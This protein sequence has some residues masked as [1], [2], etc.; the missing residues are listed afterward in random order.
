MASGRTPLNYPVTAI[1]RNTPQGSRPADILA[2]K[3]SA[4][5][6]L[7]AKAPPFPPAAGYYQADLRCRIEALMMPIDLLPV[8][9]APPIL[10][11][12]ANPTGSTD[13][14]VYHLQVRAEP[15]G[16][17]VHETCTCEW[18]AEGVSTL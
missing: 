8:T 1:T 4:R 16:A 18:A 7:S 14:L 5:D 10:R 15:T 2:R 17:W 6:K 3:R 12:S 13:L 11:C 9:D